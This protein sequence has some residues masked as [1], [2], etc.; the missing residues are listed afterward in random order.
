MLEVLRNTMNL[1]LQLKIIE[2]TT[3]FAAFTVFTVYLEEI[4]A[5]NINCSNGN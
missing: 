3:A 4:I 2:L 5:R 1:I